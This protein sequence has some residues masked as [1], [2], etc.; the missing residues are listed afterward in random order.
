MFSAENERVA[1]AKAVDPVNKNVE[2]WMGE[3]EEMMKLSV[4]QVLFNSVQ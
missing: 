1:F 3:L 2:D 4:R